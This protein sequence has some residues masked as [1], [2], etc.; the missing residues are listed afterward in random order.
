MNYNL[1]NRILEGGNIRNLIELSLVRDTY[2]ELKSLAKKNYQRC[3]EGKWNSDEP[4]SVAVYDQPLR[5]AFTFFNCDKDHAIDWI[6]AYADKNDI[7]LGEISDT[8]KPIHLDLRVSDWSSKTKPL[9]GVNTTFTCIVLPEVQREVASKLIEAKPNY[10]VTFH[11]GPTGNKSLDLDVYAKDADEA[12]KMAYKQF[13][14]KFHTEPRYKGYSDATT[15]EIPT[16][17]SQIGIEFYYD[18]DGRKGVQI[19]FITANSEKEAVD[20]YNKT[21]KGKT[22][23]QPKPQKIDPDGSCVYGDVKH[24]YFA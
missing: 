4:V 8:D 1:I 23:W 11:D 22:F 9:D 15:M 12:F 16:G 24:T 19:M 17:P 7:I 21:Y 3:P 13:K 6:R 20:I 18:D 14:D 2:T 10:R 5:I